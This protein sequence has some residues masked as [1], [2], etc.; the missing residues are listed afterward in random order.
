M[1]FY[2]TKRSSC[3]SCAL[4]T[5]AIEE[6][7]L[8]VVLGDKG[9]SSVINAS[10]VRGDTKGAII[11]KIQSSGQLVNVHKECRKR[12]TDLRNVNSSE[13]EKP[14]PVKKTRSS[15]ES[16]EWEKC[17]LFCG[18][19]CETHKER[20]QVCLVQTISF[21]RN[22]L[23]VCRIKPSDE[24]LL[25][26]I[27]HRVQNCIDLVAVKARYH[28]T[29][30]AKFFKIKHSAKVH[31]DEKAPCLIEEEE[32]KPGKPKDQVATKAFE[33]T[34]EWLESTAE[35]LFLCEVEEHMNEIAGDEHMW[36]RRYIQEQLVQ[37]YGD[38]IEVTNEGYRNI[39]RLKDIR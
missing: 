24:P 13:D 2:V 5:N 14:P 15:F 29:C 9:I 21:A 27:A 28:K 38:H 23:D 22:I 39:V 37:K 25:S 33:E 12:Y 4:C 10:H 32:K 3:V 11:E 34:C 20:K 35:P 7:S 19:Q 30:S 16:F 1:D 36:S 8:G 6:T 17:C 31:S 26:A 18:S